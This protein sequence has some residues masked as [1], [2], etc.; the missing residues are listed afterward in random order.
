[1]KHSCF[2]SLNSGHYKTVRQNLNRLER[3]FTGRKWTRFALL[4]SLLALLTPNKPIQRRVW[5]SA[6][7]MNFR[8]NRHLGTRWY[9]AGFK[10]RVSAPKNTA[11][12]F[13]KLIIL[14]FRIFHSLM[15]L[16]CACASLLSRG[17]V[18]LSHFNRYFF[19]FSN[20]VLASSFMGGGTYFSG[21]GSGS[22][23]I[24]I[25]ATLRANKVC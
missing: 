21:T 15:K 7:E 3:S 11:K 25:R 1:M 23:A 5:M 14:F 22:L 8:C 10:I 2:I 18:S 4:N 17:P 16:D 24:S 6:A 9:Q 20:L 13:W 12:T 19:I